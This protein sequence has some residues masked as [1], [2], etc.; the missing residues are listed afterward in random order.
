MEGYLSSSQD[1]SIGK[2]FFMSFHSRIIDEKEVF[3]IVDMLVGGGG[4]VRSLLPLGLCGTHLLGHHWSGNEV[5]SKERTRF[6]E[7]E[8]KIS[9]F[10]EE[11]RWVRGRS[12]RQGKGEM[13]FS[14]QT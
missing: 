9:K 14:F 1:F 4:G 11:W 12:H 7:E 2:S 10:G 5:E 13:R 3:V 8:V 6:E